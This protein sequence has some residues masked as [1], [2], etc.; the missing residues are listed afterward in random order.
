[1]HGN[2]N[3]WNF[4]CNKSSLD[5][6]KN[7]SSNSLFQNKKLSAKN[8][9]KIITGNLNINTLPNKFDQLKN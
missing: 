3:S 8:T 7:A 4:P 2:S 5:S 9:K 1:M 6:I